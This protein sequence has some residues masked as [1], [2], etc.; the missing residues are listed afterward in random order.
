[1]FTLN[2]LESV[3]AI[4][5]A[6]VPPTPAYAWPLL[7][8]RVGAETIVKHE[9]HT[10]TGSFKVRGGLAYIDALRRARHMPAALIT[11]TRGNHG[12]SIAMAAAQNDIQAIIVVPEGN[13]SEKNAAM[14]AF[15]GQLVVAGKDFDES[16]T[17]AA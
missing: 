13:S 11:A 7:A 10:P 16:R 12:Q 3:T 5:R 9:N 6:F 15:G 17:I 4:V 8:K 1:M 14:E 2:E